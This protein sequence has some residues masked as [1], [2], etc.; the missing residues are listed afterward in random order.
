[1][2][3]FASISD[4]ELKWSWDTDAPAEWTLQVEVSRTGRRSRG[5]FGLLDS[6]S[7]V[8][9]IPEATRIEGLVRAGKDDVL[10]QRCVLVFPGKMCPGLAAG[11]TV[12][13][14][15]RAGGDCFAIEQV[16]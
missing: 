3:P 4:W 1:M 5:L 12:R 6:P 9:A 13:L 8:G 16:S 14:S 15:V 7:M 10:G 2:W 11:D